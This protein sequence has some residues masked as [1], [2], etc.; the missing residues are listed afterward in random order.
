MAG[1]VR[2]EW[3]AQR[4]T[5]EETKNTKNA[6]WLGSWYTFPDRF[7]MVF[8]RHRSVPCRI[9]MCTVCYKEPMECTCE[10]WWSI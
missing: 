5:Q 7:E 1:R 4:L 9:M 2:V 3:F 10:V 6:R 8:D